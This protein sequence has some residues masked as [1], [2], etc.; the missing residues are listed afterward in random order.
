MNTPLNVA[1]VS[2]L[3]ASPITRTVTSLWIRCTE[4]MSTGEG[5]RTLIGGFPRLTTLA[6]KE[7][8]VYPGLEA[9]LSASVLGRLEQITLKNCKGDEN[10][11]V[12]QLRSEAPKLNIHT[13]R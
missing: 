13:L 2:R 1:Q 9:L 11:L 3:L 8:A 12:K 4:S 5:I 6:L 10:E 7:F